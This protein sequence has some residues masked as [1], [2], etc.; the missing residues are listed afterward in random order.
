MMGG[1]ENGMRGYLL[2]FLIAYTR[3]FAADYY[4]AAESFETSCPWSNVA[5]LCSR[6]KKRIW[7]EAAKYGFPQDKVWISFRITQ[8]YNT[9]AAVYVYFSLQY[10]GFDKSKIVE[11]Y[12]KVEDAA[13]DETML[14]GGCISH[15]HGVGKIRKSFIHRTLP[16]MALDWQKHIKDAIDPNNVFAINNTVPRSE[17]EKQK[18][19]NKH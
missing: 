18:L 7:D 15:H 4:V 3:D 6:V 16:E 13:R 2:T 5:N 14:C 8:L 1:S 19:K 12:E 17:E 9:G 11:T 10:Y